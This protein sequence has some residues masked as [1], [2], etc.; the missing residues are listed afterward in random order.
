MNNKHERIWQCYAPLD[1]EYDAPI[2]KALTAIE[3]IED[4]PNDFEIADIKSKRNRGIRISFEN[5][6]SCNHEVQRILDWLS[7]E[8]KCF[9]KEERQR[10]WAFAQGMSDIDYAKPS[11]EMQEMIEQEIRGEITTADIK[12][13]LDEIYSKKQ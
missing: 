3:Q 11:S 13:R 4:L 7:D 8:T 12:R 9:T 10:A 2:R 5:A 6:G 1:D